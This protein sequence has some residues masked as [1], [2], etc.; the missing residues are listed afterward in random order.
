M[1]FSGASGTSNVEATKWL[2]ENQPKRVQLHGHLPTRGVNGGFLTYSRVPSLT[3]AGVVDPCAPA[4]D[5]SDEAKAVRFGMVEYVS[6]VLVCN[7]DQ[8]IFRHPNLIEQINTVLVT[9][10]NASTPGK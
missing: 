10:P 7:A 1:P 8:D 5:D 9:G 6:R 2:V 4:P 3:P